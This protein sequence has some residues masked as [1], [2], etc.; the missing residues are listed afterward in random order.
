MTNGFYPDQTAP[1]GFALLA[2][3]RGRRELAIM[4][5]HTRVCF[6]CAVAASATILGALA[7]VLKRSRNAFQWNGGFTEILLIKAKVVGLM[8]ISNIASR[9]ALYLY[10]PFKYNYYT[11]H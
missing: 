4:P 11:L 10:E 2:Q 8:Q 7:K 5:L 6:Y 9:D 3:S 1:L